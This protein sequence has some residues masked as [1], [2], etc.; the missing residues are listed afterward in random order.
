MIKYKGHSVFPREVEELIY[1]N[2]K[3]DE[4]A[5]VGVP[6]PVAGENIKAYISLKTDFKGNISEQEL[7]KWCKENISPYKYPRIV[8]ILPELP[9]TVIGKILKRELREIYN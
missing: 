1:M 9:K 2:E 7:L 8:E 3:V 4:V 5:V 6:D